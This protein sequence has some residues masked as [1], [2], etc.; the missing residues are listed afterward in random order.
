[1]LSLIGVAVIGGVPV[2]ASDW[3]ENG[4]MNEYLKNQEGVDIL[5]LVRRIFFTYTPDDPMLVPRCKEW[6]VAL[7]TL[8]ILMSFT[9]I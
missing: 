1:M 4:T 5:E 3:M 9:L 2:L 7:N 8:T 6:Q